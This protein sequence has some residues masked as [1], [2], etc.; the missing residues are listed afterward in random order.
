MSRPKLTVLSQSDIEQIHDATI[1]VLR[2]TGV[3]IKDPE[4]R[5][6]LG[7]EGAIV[8]EET[9]RVRI[10]SE[11]IDE[12]IRRTPD[13]F[14]LYGRDTEL[15]YPV[16]TEHL[17]FEPMIGRL[18]IHDFEKDHIRR[19]TLQDVGKLVKVSDACGNYQLLHSG[20]IM[21]EIEG[22]EIGLSHVYGYRESVRNSSKVIKTSSRDRL[23]AEEMVE[24][25]IAV[26]GGEEE[27]RKKP[28]T[29]ST[30]NPVAPLH[31][32]LDQTA[33]MLV[34][35]RYGLP[36]DITSE[37]QAGAT[38]PVTLA[39]LLTQQN[40][41]ILS[42]IVI[43]QFANSGTPLW[44][45]TAGAIMDMKIGRIALGSIEAALINA[46]SA[47]IA[48]FYNIPAR[49][50]GAVTES[51]LLDFQAG[52]ESALTLFFCALSGTN[53]IFYPGT[54]EGGLTISL[55]RLVIDNEWAGMAY[56]TLDGIVVDEERLAVDVINSVGPCGHYLGEAFTMK[57]LR[58]EQ[59]LPELLSR[60]TRSV[61]EQ[62]KKSIGDIAHGR[63]EGILADHKPMP[64]EEKV[65]EELIRIIRKAEERRKK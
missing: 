51:K 7:R 57:H 37:P 42:G 24:M 52:A 55:E 38:A 26:A 34:F 21:P 29:F 28:N 48:H 23:I 47:Q 15:V 46:A 32:D 14:T 50:T 61:W 36:I 60:E 12:A 63:V 27:L 10:P 13:S 25:A 19:T 22:V 30:A 41:D 53:L 58:E 8:D 18:Y 2:E 65:E 56:R 59:Y 11:M 5:K 64:L 3:V 4:A 16:D 33:G 6:I 9:L 35:G 40:A 1:R 62:E 54:M 17:Y 43:A 31:H 20:A 39:G 44:Y 45:G 49:G